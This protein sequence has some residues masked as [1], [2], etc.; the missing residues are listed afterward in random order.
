MTF[1]LSTHFT[2]YGKVGINSF[3]I[4]AQRS[5][6][7]GRWKGQMWKYKASDVVYDDNDIIVYK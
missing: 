1:Y 6:G 2:C 3:S 5:G 7:T 4:I